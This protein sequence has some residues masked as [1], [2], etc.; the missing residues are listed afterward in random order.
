MNHALAR[1]AAGL[2][3][4]ALLLLAH[5]CHG[6]YTVQPLVVQWPAQGAGAT[7]GV[8][9]TIQLNT[10]I[11]TDAKT[12]RTW[13]LSPAGHDETPPVVWLPILTFDPT[14]VIE[15]RNATNAAGTNIPHAPP[16]K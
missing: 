5:L 6:Q 14:A 7:I 12:G 1:L 11:M 4:G 8:N 13:I 9:R 15:L 10:A 16:A 2:I 3:L